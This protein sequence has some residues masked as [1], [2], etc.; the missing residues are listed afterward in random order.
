[1][2][3]W[4]SSNSSKGE[5]SYPAAAPGPAGDVPARIY[6]VAETQDRQMDPDLDLDLYLHLNLVRSLKT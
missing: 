1:M 2:E 3:G 6:A 5:G 4:G